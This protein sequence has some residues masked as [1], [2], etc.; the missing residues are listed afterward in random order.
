V[1][2]SSRYVPKATC[3]TR[4]IAA[5]IL[6]NRAGL[7]NELHIGV[8]RGA[9]FDAHAW[10]ECEGQVLVGMSERHGDYSRILTIAAG[11]RCESPGGGIR[12]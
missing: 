4:A 7:P 11:S 3:L 12:C 9:A 6:L 8:A 2:L 5:Q 1:R 10:I